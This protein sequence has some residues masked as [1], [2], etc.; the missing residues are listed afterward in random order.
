MNT[1][2]RELLN[3]SLP[4]SSL[5]SCSRITRGRFINL[6]HLTEKSQ[7]KM[8]PTHQ[9]RQLWPLFPDRW[10]PKAI[11][12]KVPLHHPPPPPPCLV[13]PIPLPLLAPL[14]LCFLFSLSHPHLSNTRSL[15]SSYPPWRCWDRENF[16][17]EKIH[18]K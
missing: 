4:S 10:K 14:S 1:M 15:L 9:L 6:S 8:A 18:K 16:F 5:E 3:P 2:R 7:K 17:L 12:T 13:F 11:S